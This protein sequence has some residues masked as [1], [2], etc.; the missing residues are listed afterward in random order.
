MLSGTEQNYKECEQFIEHHYDRLLGELQEW[1]KIKSISTLPEHS[2]EVVQAAEWV[3]KKI[4]RIGFPAVSLI[5]T[6]SHPLVYG[7]WS[8][9]ENQPTL[10]VYGHYDVQPVD[11][12]SEWETPPFEPVV[13]GD[14]LYCRGASD[15]KSQI[16]L[17]LA[18]LE[19][20]I[21]VTGAP[22]V[23]VKILLE[24][25][26]EAGG[27]SIERYVHEQKEQ[28]QADAAL[29]CDTHMIHSDQ[30]SLICGLRGILYTE[31]KMTGPATDLHSGSYGGIAPNPLHGL[32]V[33]VSKLKGEDGV[34]N[35]PE[36][37]GTAEVVG[38]GE[39]KF[40]AEDPLQIE[41]GLKEEMGVEMFV[42][43]G[44]HTPLERVG[45]QPTLEVHGIKGGF[46]GDGAKTV[47]PAEAVAK[48]SMRLPAGL[49]PDEVFVWL[50]RA[51]KNNCPAGHKV[52][53]TQIHG[54]RGVSVNQENIFMKASGTALESVYGTEPV[55]MREG[56]SI[57]VAALFESEMDIPVVLMGFGLPDDGAH[58]PN[59]KFSL[60]QLKRGMKT[61]AE[62]LGRIQTDSK[63]IS[64]KGRS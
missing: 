1:L 55:F 26:E 44:S 21:D 3:K 49:N 18:A 2:S 45:L 16:L 5:V 47:I 56:G 25:E 28:L 14:N 17:V 8:G 32:C 33:L 58:A 59:E 35:I 60:N 48:V 42:G 51:V 6:G 11:P 36:L 52:E 31:I 46:V 53:I 40:L 34:I 38:Q 15:D 54:G 61:V 7:E 64:D 10:L 37:D 23:N 41:K 30:P 50:E 24:G 22:P 27:L 13:R 57:P 20:W 19:A 63:E 9:L 62:L 12:L 4:E 39:K 29:I 43:N